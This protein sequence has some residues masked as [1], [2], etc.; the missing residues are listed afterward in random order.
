MV[1]FFRIMRQRG[2]GL[3]ELMLSLAIIAILLIMATRYYQTASNNN[4]INS[5]VDMANGVKS[6]VKNFMNSNMNSTTLPTVS[7]LVANG[8]LPNDYSNPSSANPWGG[9]ICVGS[10]GTSPTCVDG[11]GGNLVNSTFS[12]TF[13]QIPPSICNQVQA[14]IQ[15]TL[16]AG[17]VETASCSA[18]ASGTTT[19]SLVIIYLL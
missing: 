17:G 10:G 15:T 12:V 16:A 5:A 11:T 18:G 19:D 1:S 9:D 8:Y 2:I 14:R 6:A 7:D 4:A 3:L 13:T